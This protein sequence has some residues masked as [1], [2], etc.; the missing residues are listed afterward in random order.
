M[1]KVIK[2]KNVLLIWGF[3]LYFNKIIKI[4]INIVYVN[5]I[6]INLLG[7]KSK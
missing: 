1:Y 6:V 4:L 3:I 5:V 7:F 2:F